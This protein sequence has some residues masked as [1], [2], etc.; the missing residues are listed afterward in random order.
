MQFLVLIFKFLLLPELPLE[1]L[2]EQRLEEDLMESY[3]DL[4]D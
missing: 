3:Q 4:D 2:N 1:E